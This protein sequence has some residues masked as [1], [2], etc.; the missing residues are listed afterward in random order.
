MI[1][2]NDPHVEGKKMNNRRTTNIPAHKKVS[3]KGKPFR[4]SAHPRNLGRKPVRRIIFNEGA[5]RVSDKAADELSGELE[6]HGSK[7]SRRAVE[8]ARKDGR[9]TVKDR[10][11]KQAASE[12]HTSFHKE[13]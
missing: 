7:I 9:K 13:K 4:V 11:I 12:F 10:D 5:V 2:V 1:L 3:K 6:L 8:L